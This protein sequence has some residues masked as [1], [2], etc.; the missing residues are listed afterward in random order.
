MVICVMAREGWRELEVG[1]RVVEADNFERIKN[2]RH[3][4]LG[5]E[6][7]GHVTFETCDEVSRKEGDEEEKSIGADSWSW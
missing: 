2:G 4:H 3:N 7:L 6:V 1:V 5:A